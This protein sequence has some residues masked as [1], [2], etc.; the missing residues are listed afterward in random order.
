MSADYL[1][2]LAQ[3]LSGLLAITFAVLTF[4]AERTVRR[5]R[6]LDSA[7]QTNLVLL[8]LVSAAAALLAALTWSAW[9]AT[10]PDVDLLL[11]WSARVWLALVFGFG[12]VAATGCLAVAAFALIRFR[13]A[14]RGSGDWE[15]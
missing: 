14:G 13:R 11:N 10:T 1:L 7:Y 6:A 12:A 2:A 5:H 15:P 3:G 9:E 8:I 4:L